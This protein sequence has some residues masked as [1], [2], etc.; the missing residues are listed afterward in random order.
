MEQDE[1]QLFRRSQ[2]GD[3]DAL[4]ELLARYLPQLHAFVR[5]RAGAE[6]RARESSMDLV[7]SVCRELL[8]VAPRFEDRG[9][10]RFRAWLFTSALN[11][12]RDKRR[13]HRSQKRDPAREVEPD[14]EEPSLA[15]ASYLT[16]SVDAMGREAAL[17]L[18]QALGALREEHREVIAMARVAKLPHAVIAETLGRSEAAVRQLLVRALLELAREL[19]ARGFDLDRVEEERR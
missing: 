6:L 19:R 17:A 11:K 16:P 14:D 4:R 3:E 8:S 1:D 7:Q 5:L 2:G 12:L 15:A 9:E 18:E 13:F 10:D